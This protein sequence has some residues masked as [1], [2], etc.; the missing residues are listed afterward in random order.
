M[1]IAAVAIGRNEGERLRRCLTS[2]RPHV[3]RLVYVDSGS[4][5]DSVSFA[6]GIGAHVVEL[7]G[8]IPFTAARAR[9][10]GFAALRV[11]T[12]PSYVQFVDGDCAID[13]HWIGAA[14]AALDA[15][16][17][18]A[19]VTGWRTEIDPDANAYHAIAEV[20]WHQPAGEIAACGGDMMVRASAFE[21]VGGFDPK[22]I[23]SED[24][25]FVIRVREAGFRA[26]RLP[27]VMTRHDIAMTRLREWW[28][29]NLRSGN[30]MAEVG[31]LRP[32]H[33]RPERRR[34]V[35]FGFVLPLM[36][37][38]GLVS[39]LWWLWLPAVVGYAVSAG[40][41]WSW[42]RRGGMAPWLA[43][44]VAGLFTLAKLPQ[45]IG[46]ARFYLRGGRKATGRIIEYK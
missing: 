26:V 6:R 35:V 4:T 9:N 3:S 16:P 40:R 22:I 42:L 31:D 10:A 7:D 2:L 23:A 14:A 24:E 32:P 41:V 15:D 13:P 8:S 29:R 5:D 33:F 27:L 37:L 39:G 45:F 17:S 46:M 36:L 25:D 44:R 21:A 34:A 19:I 1:T 18:L 20:E 30:G 38:A 12:A 28:R 11:E 43:L